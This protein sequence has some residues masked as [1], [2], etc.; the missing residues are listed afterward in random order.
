MKAL[1]SMGRRHWARLAIRVLRL[2]LSRHDPTSGLVRQSY[3]RIA[4]GYD[5]AWTGH[6]R[7]FSLELLDRLGPRPGARCLDLTC[8]TGFITRELARR[9][10]GRVL[11]VDAS[12]GMLEAARREHGDCCEFVCAD[13]VAL[14]GSLPASSFDVVT[15]GWGL[16][17]TRPLTVVRETARVLRS[18]GRLAIIDNTLFSLARVLWSSVLAFAEQPAALAHVMRFRFL[19]H[20]CVLAAMLRMCGLQVRA[21]WDGSKS[22]HVA[23]G[24]EAIARLTATGAAAGFEFAADP[25]RRDAVFARFAEIIEKRSSTPQGIPITHRYLAAI[26]EKR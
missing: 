25:A 9:C 4:P 14:L 10:G 16:G 1:V 11:G 23:G 26:G 3:D 19:P 5:E 15:C 6:M 2:G 21:A 17:Y 12:P 18:G 24:S 7:R 8:G 22:Y 20:S 13:A